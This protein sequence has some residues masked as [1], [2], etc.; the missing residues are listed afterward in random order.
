MESNIYLLQKSINTYFKEIDLSNKVII[1]DK[2]INAMLFDNIYTANSFKT[3]LKKHY[4][5][6]F[7]VIQI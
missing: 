6:K 4:S 2:S 3:L 7:K 1:S 5:E